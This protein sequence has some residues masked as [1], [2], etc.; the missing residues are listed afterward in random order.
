MNRTLYFDI[1]TTGLN[2]QSDSITAIQYLY[3]DSGRP[4]VHINAELV[5]DLTSENADIRMCKNET[6]L[7]RE[8]TKMSMGNLLTG[9][10]VS[11]GHFVGKTREK[12]RDGFDIP[13]IAARMCHHGFDLKDSLGVYYLKK[14]DSITPRNIENFVCIDMMFAYNSFIKPTAADLSLKTI[15]H[16]ENLLAKLD[17]QGVFATWH[18]DNPQEWLEYAIR[19]VVILK[20][21]DDKQKIIDVAKAMVEK[22][23][24]DIKDVMSKGKLW[25]GIISKYITKNKIKIGD[26]VE[27]THK[28]I[29][30]GGGMTIDPVIFM[31]YNDV[32][33]FDVMSMYPT[34]IQAF[35]L[36]SETL[37]EPCDIKHLYYDKGKLLTE[38]EAIEYV[39]KHDEKNEERRKRGVGPSKLDLVVKY[40]GTEEEA[41]KILNSGYEEKSDVITAYSGAKF[42]NSK[43]GILPA[44]LVDMFAERKRYK[45]IMAVSE[46]IEYDRAD[47]MQKVIKVCMNSLYGIVGMKGFDYTSESIQTTITSNAHLILTLVRKAIDSAGFKVIYGD[48]DSVFVKCP[49]DDKEK[50][51]AVIKEALEK[52]SKYYSLRKDFVMEYEKYFRKALFPAKKSYFYINEK[53]EYKYNGGIFGNSKAG[54]LVNEWNEKYGE[55]YYFADDDT[56]VKAL[57]AMI[58]DDVK[59]SYICKMEKRNNSTYKDKLKGSVAF[60]KERYGVEYKGYDHVMKSYINTTFTYV[61]KSGKET[62]SNEILIPYDIY[63]DDDSIYSDIIDLN[64]K[65]ANVAKQLNSYFWKT[66]AIKALRAEEKGL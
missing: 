26:L 42:D 62:K 38:D 53:G 33:V 5:G 36:S 24:C 6:E 52:F 7:L 20:E 55:A 61:S 19:D 58:T 29:A 31:R 40:E 32:A 3:A 41:D 37:I 25:N 39:N 18:L 63:N 59:I 1:E 43:Q 54:K 56:A 35:N 49:Y 17:V 8:F 10:N 30:H 45:D 11:G 44:V 16:N 21:L 12:R 13:F 64:C 57:L 2:N 9:W 23:G 28:P 22:T 15:A 14:I 48:T 50:V 47:V 4:I 60:L 34:S 65:K 46:G 27:D 66:K 51:A